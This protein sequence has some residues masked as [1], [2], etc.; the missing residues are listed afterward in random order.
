M[1]AGES[2]LL[3]LSF[4][5]H[6]CAMHLEASGQLWGVGSPSMWIQGWVRVV[7]MTVWEASLPSG[8]PLASFPVS[9]RR[10]KDTL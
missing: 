8:P 4:D 10:R 5:L 7:I 6:T 2:Q 9:K 3:Q 1:V